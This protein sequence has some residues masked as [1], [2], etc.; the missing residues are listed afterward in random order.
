[1]LVVTAGGWH[2][3]YPYR[4]GRFANEE[5]PE[6]PRLGVQY[7]ICV[8]HFTGHNGATQFMP[9]SHLFKVTVQPT[10]HCVSFVGL[11]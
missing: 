7:T 11:C 1:M 10:C 8:D 6:F 4:P 5:W 3:D 2:S 9:G